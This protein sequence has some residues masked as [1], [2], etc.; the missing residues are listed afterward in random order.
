MKIYK[1]TIIFDY[2]EFLKNQGS[3][4]GQKEWAY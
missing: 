3:L 2:V 1:I 4:I